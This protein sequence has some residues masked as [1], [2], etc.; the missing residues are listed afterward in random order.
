VSSG[1]RSDPRA[2]PHPISDRYRA[3]YVPLATLEF[4]RDRKSMSLLARPANSHVPT[5]SARSSMTT[6]SAAAAAAAGQG[7]NVLLVKGA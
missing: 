6:R 7:T 5:P 1:R 4:D 2:H 3:R